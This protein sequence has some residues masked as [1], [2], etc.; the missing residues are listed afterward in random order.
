MSTSLKVVSIAASF[1]ASFSRDA[2]RSR[3]RVIFTRFS[4]G[5]SSAAGAACAAGVAWALGGGGGS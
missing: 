5:A 4:R 3:I 1:C 2:M